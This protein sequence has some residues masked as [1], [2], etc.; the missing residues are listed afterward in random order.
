M[1]TGDLLLQLDDA[2]DERLGPR[3]AAG[4]VDV[5]R[6]HLIHALD[7]RVVIEDAPDGSARPHGD[8]PLRFRHLIVDATQGRRH[9]SR[10]SAG[11]DHQIR[12]AW[13]AAEYFGAE[14]RDVV[15]A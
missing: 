9:F 1:L 11:H 8:H 10:Q 13:A 14:P 4:D 5:Y 7:D 3:R 6:H 2:V 15:A 12:L